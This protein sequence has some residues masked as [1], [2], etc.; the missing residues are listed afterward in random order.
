MR[1]A[2]HRL[3]QMDEE[4]LEPD[5]PI[6]DPHHHLWTHNPPGAYRVR[7]FWADTGSGHR[8][9]QTVFIQCGTNPCR[10]GPPELRPV[11]ETE[12]VVG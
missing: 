6:V 5:L 2:A 4:V 3:S 11:G 1:N 8:I 7:E 12:F 10:D 9:E